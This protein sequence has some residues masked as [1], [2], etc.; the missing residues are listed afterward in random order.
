MF[1]RIVI[2]LRQRDLAVEVGAALATAGCG[3]VFL[4]NPSTTLDLLRG[5]EAVGLLVTG[6]DFGSKKPRASELVRACR[7]HNPATRI[8]CVGEAEP[9]DSDAFVALPC[10]AIEIN[11]K[12]IGILSSRLS[13]LIPQC[14]RHVPAHSTEPASLC[15]KRPSRAAKVA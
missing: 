6:T 8:L 11:R 7:Y 10:G 4:A 9:P 13:L 14:A 12:A 15:M 3:S 2:V 1:G 5:A